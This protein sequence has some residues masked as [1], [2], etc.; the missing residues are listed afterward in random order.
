MTK[1][2]LAVALRPETIALLKELS[3]GAETSVSQV[4]QLAI[5]NSFPLSEDNE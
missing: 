4:V 3:E 2:T 5:D 1:Q